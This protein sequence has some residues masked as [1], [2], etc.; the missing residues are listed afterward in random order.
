MEHLETALLF[1]KIA[2]LAIVFAGCVYL[3]MNVVDLEIQFWKAFA[4]FCIF[5][6]LWRAMIFL[7]ELVFETRWF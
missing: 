7:M 5:L 6:T 3:T 4:Y 2:Y 1:A